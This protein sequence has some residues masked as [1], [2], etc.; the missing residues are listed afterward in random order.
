ML[1]NREDLTPRKRKLVQKPLL[2]ENLTRAG[3]W[4]WK[5]YDV[6]ARALGR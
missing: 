5:S 4:V 1:R 2:A 3:R 6:G